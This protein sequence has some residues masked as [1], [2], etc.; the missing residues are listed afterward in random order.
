MLMSVLEEMTTAV[1]QLRALIYQAV[2]A[3]IVLMDIVAME[4]AVLVSL[5][6]LSC[7]SVIR[8]TVLIDNLHNYCIPIDNLSYITKHSH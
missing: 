7:Q 4:S 8:K 2:S 3:V 6:L 5:Y 1:V